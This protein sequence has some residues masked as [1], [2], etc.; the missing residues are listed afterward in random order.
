MDNQPI[1]YHIDKMLTEF[2]EESLRAVYMVV[3]Q[4]YALQKPHN[5][6]NIKYN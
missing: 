4:M 6:D 5:K 3:R 1:I 2:E